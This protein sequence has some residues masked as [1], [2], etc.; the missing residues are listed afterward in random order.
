V[1]FGEFLAGSIELL[2]VL[3][4]IG[5]GAIRL[6]ARLLSGWSGAPA[7]LAEVVLGISLLVIVLELIGVVGLYRPGW[8]LVAAIAAGI[9]VGVAAGRKSGGKGI[10]LPAPA[11]GAVGIGVAT[12]AALLVAAHWAMPTQTG[13]DIGMYLPNTTWHNAPFAARFVQD[14][15]VGALHMTE[16]LK[17]TVWFYPQNSELLHSVGLLF[18]GTDFLSPLMNI[19]WMALCLFAAWCFGRPYAAGAAAVLGMALI[20]DAEMLLLYQPGDAKNDTIG[21]F[22]LL[23]SVAILVN[24][25]AQSRAAAGAARTLHSGGPGLRPMLSRGVLIVAALAA[26]LALG[27]KLNLLAPFGLLTLGVIAVARAG[28]RIRTGAIWVACSLLTGG[29]WFARNL[30]ESGNPLP[31]ADKGPLPGPEQF[32]IDIREGH[33]VADYLTNGKVIKDSLIP[34]LDDSFGVL[35]PLTL[36]VVLAGIALAIWR[37]RTT[38]LRMLGVVA[39]FSGIAYLVTPLTA[40]GPQGDPNAFEVNL[41]YASPALAL[42]VLLLAVDAG[43]GRERIRNLVLGG[44]SLLLVVGLFSGG[45]D[46]W[47]SDYAVGAVALAL[48]VIGVPVLL[49]YASRRGMGWPAV[50]AAAALAVGLAIGIGWAKNDDYI[51]DRYQAATA[52]GDFPEGIRSALELFNEEDPTDSRVAVVGGR[53]GFKQYVF[54]GR[55]LSNHVQYVAHEGSHGAYT[56]IATDPRRTSDVAACEEW[57]TALN[58]GDYDYAVIGPDQR[59]QAISPVEATW[60]NGDPAAAVLLED[61]LTFVFA[62]DG[63]LDPGRCEGIRDFTPLD[64]GQAGQPKPAQ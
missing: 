43:L 57:L 44:L 25:D 29:F 46:V 23:A 10:E 34:G 5:F 15:Q 19:G 4:A 17:L 53:P 9:G 47:Q 11:V 35:W 62:I 61:E 7:R 1:T 37:G 20:L 54:Y 27:T 60:L 31:W 12:A 39:L 8:V 16:V 45:E 32:D 50:A 56:P 28:D 22:F 64:E 48:F 58:D 33:T 51:N 2:A 30:V 40:A 18:L 41:R 52:P 36:A 21:L 49:A 59:T 55:D 24:G 26:G 38:M 14:A 42:G 6:R 63:E 3:C 13:L